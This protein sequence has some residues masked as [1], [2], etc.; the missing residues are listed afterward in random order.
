MKE[1]LLDKFLL[2]TVDLMNLLNISQNTITRW[3]SQGK[4]IAHRLPGT[5]KNYFDRHEV[6]EQLQLP[7]LKTSKNNEN[8]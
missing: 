3:I 4:I 2:D 8:Q 1:N 6:E 5:R 7:H